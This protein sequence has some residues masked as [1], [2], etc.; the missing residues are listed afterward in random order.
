MTTAP[1]ST[2]PVAVLVGPPGSGKTV[3]GQ[4]LA[5]LLGLPFDDTDERV[6]AAAG[7]SIA[8]IFVD[9]GEAAFRSLERD[10][11]AAAL[12]GSRGV[13]ALGGGA[14]MQEQ[15]RELLAGH[16][17]VF[18]DV[19]IADA[20]RRVGFDGARPLLAVNPRASWIALMKVRRPVYEALATVRVDT[21]G[22]TPQ[23]VAAEAAQAL[24]LTPS[25]PEGTP[26]ATPEGA[27]A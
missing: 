13:V 23:D 11:V 18:L 22:R 12:A 9:D 16:R 20:A 17:V 2:G 14:P 8:E 6:V 3:T 7:R 10:A 15:V 25:A 1:R 26:D 24:G 5:E 27:G 19:G 21:A 4:A